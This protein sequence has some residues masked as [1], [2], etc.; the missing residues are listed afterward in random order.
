[1]RPVGVALVGCGEIAASK[2]LS[3]LS[4]LEGTACLGFL[5]GRSSVYREKW[6]AK[7]AVTY[8]SMEQLCADDRIDAVIIC[9]PNNTHAEYAIAALEAGKHVICEKPMAL[10]AGDAAR[11]VQ[12]AEKNGCILTIGHQSRF[13]PAAQYL[14]ELCASG[15]LGTIYYVRSE[16]LRRR[17]VPTWGHFLNKERQGGGCLIDLGTHAIDLALWML[18][19]FSPVW[20][21]GSTYQGLA[22]QPTEANRWGAWKSDHYEVEDAAF[23]TVRMAS[24]AT[25]EIASSFALNIPEDREDVL[26]LC[27]TKGGATL[28]GGKL[29]LNGVRDDAFFNETIDLAADWETACKKQVEDFIDCIRTGRQPLVTAREGLGVSRVLDGIYRSAA[30]K[31]PVML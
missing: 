6:G 2:Y 21:M 16:M 15:A 20:A 10:T 29:T 5:G 22:D 11:M 1:M 14:H 26:T 25:L 31:Q 19:D 7:D 24:G 12:A 30:E 17:G 3:N 27:G 9:T 23:G 8:T 18:G 13:S 4:S 28:Q